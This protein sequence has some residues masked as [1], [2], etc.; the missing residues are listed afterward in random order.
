[1]A[2]ISF[3]QIRQLLESEDFELQPTQRK[4]CLPILQ[5]I[6]HKMNVGVEFDSINIAGDLLINGHHR[7]VCSLLLKKTLQRDIWSR[8]SQVHTYKWPQIQIDLDDWESVEIIERHNRKDAAISGLDIKI[9]E[10]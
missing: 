1:M 5:R 7:Y 8:P 10:I 3:E 9:L 6:Y 4:L 2:L